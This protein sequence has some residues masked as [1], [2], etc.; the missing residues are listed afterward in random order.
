MSGK[1]SRSLLVIVSAILLLSVFGATSLRAAEG[2]TPK[3]RMAIL[4]GL[5][6]EYCTTRVALPLG[7]KGVELSTAGEIDQESLTREMAQNGSAAQQNQLVQ[8]TAIAFRDKEILFEINGG[9]KKKTKWTDRIEVGMGSNTTPLSRQDGKKAVGSYITI[10][11]N[12]K[13]PDLTVDELKAMLNT[14]LDFTPV[15]P[16]QSMNVVVPEEFKEAVEAKKAEVGMSMDVVRLSMGP[17]DQKVRETKDGVEQEDWIYGK[18]PLRM[19]F[20]TFEDDVVVKVEEMQGGV[21]GSIQDYPK[22]PPR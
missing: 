19:I 6:A 9:G 5:I 15:N 2:L 16:M 17:P 1:L 7:E 10:D 4:R 12:G 8:I 11:F 20:V 3:S 21:H 22:Q 18:P 13:L 14:V